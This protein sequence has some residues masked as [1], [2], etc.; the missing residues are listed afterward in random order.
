M[1]KTQEKKTTKQP[2]KKAPCHCLRAL[3][4]SLGSTG[5][6]ISIASS[7]AA[8]IESIIFKAAV[9]TI[10]IE[11]HN[12]LPNREM[13]ANMSYTSKLQFKK[14]KCAKRRISTS[15]H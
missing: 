9:Y 13:N 12:R 1:S 5:F 6:I 15:R 8:L 11:V 7:N 4:W 2:K 14:K 10:F 3:G